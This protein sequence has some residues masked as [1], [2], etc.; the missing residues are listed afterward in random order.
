MHFDRNLA[1][2]K[3]IKTQLLKQRAHVRNQ[4]TLNVHDYDFCKELKQTIEE[5]DE[6]LKLVGVCISFE[7]VAK[8]QLTDQIKTLVAKDADYKQYFPE[9][10]S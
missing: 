9:L 1:Q 7:E 10:Q 5:I 8:Q 4:I 2:V 6:K 3:H